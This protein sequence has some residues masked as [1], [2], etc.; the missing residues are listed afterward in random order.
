MD[1][2]MACIVLTE[3]RPFSFKDFLCFRV[4]GIEYHMTHGTFRNK[5]SRLL[6]RGIVEVVCQSVLT[7]YT[8]KGHPF[9]KPMTSYHTGVSHN[10]PI[11]RVIKDLPFD[12]QSIHDIHITFN[13]SDI[14]PVFSNIPN[15]DFHK[16]I[17][18]HDIFIPTWNIENTLTRV[19]IHNTDTVS[20]KLACTLEP[21]QFIQTQELCD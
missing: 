19:T 18:S 10:H 17:V 14:W 12:K 20:V 13:S 9:R 2:Y 21:F 1:Q 6:K 15:T 8:L 4:N 16:N 7:F 11:Y 5:I 3:H